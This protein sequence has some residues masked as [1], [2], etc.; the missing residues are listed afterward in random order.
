MP[1]SLG[2]GHAY[3]PPRSDLICRCILQLELRN[4]EDQL[5]Q[6]WECSA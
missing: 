3:A 6:V 1:S 4:R 2:A 5:A